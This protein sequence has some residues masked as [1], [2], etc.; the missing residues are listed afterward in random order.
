VISLR[1][2]NPDLFNSK[3]SYTLL[4][5]KYREIPTD[6]HHRE[7]EIFSDLLKPADYTANRDGRQTRI[8]IAASL[9]AALLLGLCVYSIVRL[10]LIKGR[11]GKGETI[12]KFQE[13]NADME[14]DQYMQ[15]RRYSSN[16]TTSQS[17]KGTQ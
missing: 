3:T 5:L 1:S 4:K 15:A 16:L 17:Q 10:R 2:K 13:F 7:I 12:I 9:V 8:I 6:K 11:G 14:R